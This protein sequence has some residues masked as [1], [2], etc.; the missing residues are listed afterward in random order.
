MP[1]W[2]FQNRAH[3]GMNSWEGA[4]A[5]VCLWL[6][7]ASAQVSPVSLVALASC[8]YCRGGWGAGGKGHHI[9]GQN[10][11]PQK[12]AS[13]LTPVSPGP[14]RPGRAPRARELNR[15]LPVGVP[16]Q[17]ADSCTNGERKKRDRREGKERKRRR[18]E[19]EMESGGERKEGSLGLNLEKRCLLQPLRRL[20]K[21]QFFELPFFSL[22][23]QSVDTV[24][25]VYY[26]D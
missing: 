14:G 13:S 18:L 7:Y 4:V 8:P 6:S 5:A 22:N 11:L 15:H 10:R 23:L 19:G 3:G 26:T 16:P 12:P 9:H 2:T 1:Q 17:R 25:Q 20:E 21:V 24:S